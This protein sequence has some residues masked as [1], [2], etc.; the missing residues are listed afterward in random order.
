MC[1]ESPAPWAQTRGS[2]QSLLF[3][4]GLCTAIETTWGAVTVEVHGLGWWPLGYLAGG[5]QDVVA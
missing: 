1:K 2:D 3:P 4:F 5:W